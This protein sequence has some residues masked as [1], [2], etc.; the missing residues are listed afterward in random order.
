MVE[1][2]TEKEL[3][4]QDMVDMAMVGV[5]DLAM[6]VDMVVILQSAMVVDMEDMVE[7]MEEVGGN[8]NNHSHSQ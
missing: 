3:L 7:D 8:T 5:M 4:K 2:T 6:V 1:A